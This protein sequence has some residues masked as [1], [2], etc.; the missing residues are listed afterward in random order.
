VRKTK[1]KPLWKTR[2]KHFYL[3]FIS[4]KLKITNKIK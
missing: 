4:H 1:Q 3:N 2:Q